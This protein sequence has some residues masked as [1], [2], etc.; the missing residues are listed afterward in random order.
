MDAL[1]E[2]KG[3]GLC[4]DNPHR[5]NGTQIQIHQC[6]SGNANHVW[7]MDKLSDYIYPISQEPTLI[8]TGG[9]EYVKIGNRQFFDVQVWLVARR[10]EN[11]YTPWSFSDGLSPGHAFIGVVG[12]DR[13]TGHWTPIRTYS[14]WPGNQGG[15]NQVPDTNLAVNQGTDFGHLVAIIEGRGHELSSRGYAVRK[16][17]QTPGRAVW[18]LNHG[19]KNTKCKFYPPTSFKEINIA[20]PSEYCH[21]AHYSTRLWNYITGGRE[22][23]EIEKLN[24]YS[25]RRED[26]K[27]SVVAAGII[28]LIESVPYAYWPDALVDT[29]EELNRQTGDFLDNGNPW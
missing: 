4:L 14:F 17:R 2:L 23:F 3:T 25:E 19:F 1:L 22:N 24:N 18:F 12:R 10:R 29:I 6:N 7:R 11:Q 13:Y 15:S 21:C 8:R 20:W 5:A 28:G 16:A 27:V 26:Q 9:T